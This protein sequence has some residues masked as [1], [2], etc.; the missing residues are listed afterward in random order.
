M[1]SGV[2]Q[3]QLC[4]KTVKKSQLFFFIALRGRCSVPQEIGHVFGCGE[5]QTNANGNMPQPEP[6]ARHAD[7]KVPPRG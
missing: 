2:Q 4:C 6:A 7:R 5:Q 1:P 3:P